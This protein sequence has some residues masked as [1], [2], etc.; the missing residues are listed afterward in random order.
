MKPRKSVSGL[1]N[2]VFFALKV[3]LPISME[4]AEK[5]VVQNRYYQT[6]S[7]GDILVLNWAIK[8]DKVR[9]SLVM[10]LALARRRSVG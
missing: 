2:S 3:R 7:K 4:D 10:G 9:D 6:Y 8:Q 1:K 5:D